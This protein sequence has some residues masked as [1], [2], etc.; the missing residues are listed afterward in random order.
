M[1]TVLYKAMNG[2]QMDFYRQSLTANNLANLNTPGFKA[3]LFQAQTLYL[4]GNTLIDDAMVVQQENGHNF[5]EGM[6]MTTGRDL[7]VAVQ[8]DGWFA[9]QDAGGKEAYTRAGD[10]KLTENGILVTASGQPVLGDGGPIS[11]PPAQSINIGT[12]GTISIVPLDSNPRELAV[13]DRI[14]LAKIDRKDLIKGN[15]GLMRLEKGGIA[16]TDPS[17]TVIKGALEGSN[18]NA[19]E[20]MVNMIAAGREFETE[21]KFMQAVDENAQ[22]LAQLLHE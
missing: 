16:P 1:D 22:R 5:S 21:M 18:V 13:L 20:Q 7:D 11:I 10:F 15:D 17:V 4:T 19:V 6:L 3:D 12:D 8:G 14:K 9:V 2:A